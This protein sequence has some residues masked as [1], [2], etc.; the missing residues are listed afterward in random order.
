MFRCINGIQDVASAE[1]RAGPSV[2]GR[3]GQCSRSMIG[4]ASSLETISMRVTP[5]QDDPIAIEVSIGL[6]PR[7]SGRS[8][9]CKLKHPLGKQPSSGFDKMCP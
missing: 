9:A 2:S 6:G 7:S 3:M 4:P 5:V 1:R 8:D